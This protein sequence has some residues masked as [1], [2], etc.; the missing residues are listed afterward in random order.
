MDKE[1]LKQYLVEVKG[2][3]PEEA[4]AKVNGMSEEEL[5]ALEEEIVA[6]AMGEVGDGDGDGDSDGDTELGGKGDDQTSEEEKKK[7]E[8]ELAAKEEEDRKAGE[9]KEKKLSSARKQLTKL[10]G[11]FR[12]SAKLMQLTAKRGK[13]LTRLS[14][15]Q[16]EAKLTPAEVKKINVVELSAKSDEAVEA[17]LKSYADREPVLPVGQVGSRK[18]ES[19]SRFSANKKM[20]ELEQRTRSNMSFLSQVQRNNRDARL[21]AGLP[22]GETGIPESALDPSANHATDVN[23]DAEYEAIAAMMDAG[24]IQGA[25]DA[26]KA[27]LAKVAAGSDGDFTDSQNAETERQLSTLVDGVSKMQN[28]FDEVMKLAGSLAAL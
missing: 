26:L 22:L 11:D 14:K 4:E 7:K 18:A 15:L 25:K 27:L 3:T 9:E 17:V 24:D 21:A 8:V 1:K 5:K 19:I 28:Q 12:S 20:S 10:S 23:M 16:A 13:I 2:M 6:W